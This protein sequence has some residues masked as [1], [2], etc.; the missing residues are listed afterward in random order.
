MEPPIAPHHD[1]C[2]GQPRAAPATR[3]TQTAGLRPAVCCAPE[4]SLLLLSFASRP[5]RRRVR[6]IWGRFWWS[7]AGRLR[8]CGQRHAS[9][10]WSAGAPRPPRI[11]AA[12]S[13]VL[14]RPLRRWPQRC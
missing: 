10:A 6:R 3:S 1:P 2:T 7:A 13:V 5:G 11:R 9:S 4:R 14:G 8:C 12:A